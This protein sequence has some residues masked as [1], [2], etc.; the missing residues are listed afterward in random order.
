MVTLEDNFGAE[1]VARVSA[2]VAHSQYLCDVAMSLLETTEQR[3]SRRRLAGGGYATEAPRPRRPV[4]SEEPADHAD[5]RARAH[6]T[7]VDQ[8]RTPR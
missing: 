4:R 1:A 8:P 6:P 5:G 3:L 7:P 2:R